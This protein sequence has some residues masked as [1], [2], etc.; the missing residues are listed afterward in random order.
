LYL[1]DDKYLQLDKNIPILSR[2]PNLKSLHIENDG[3]KKLPYNIFELNNLE[4]LYLNN[5]QLKK[6]P[7]EL[8]QLKNLKYLDLHENKL[9]RPNQMN[10]QQGFGPKIRF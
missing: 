9:K 8:I 10:E 2:L 4:Y 5:N 1:N 3:L 6:V 7:I